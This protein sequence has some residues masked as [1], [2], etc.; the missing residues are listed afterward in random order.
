M[1]VSECT[2]HYTTHCT[3]YDTVLVIHMVV[4]VFRIGSA[5]PPAVPTLPLP[6]VKD[7]LTSDSVQASSKIAKGEE[8][9]QRRLRAKSDL[10]NPYRFHDI[11]TLSGFDDEARAR[12]ILQDLSSD[13]GVIAVMKKHKWSV[14]CLSEMYPEVIR[15]KISKIYMIIPDK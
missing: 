12:A 13:P 14:G 8:D 3:L 10:A 9:F 15:C 7:D 5:P 4:C 11:H 6:R 1:C 2:V